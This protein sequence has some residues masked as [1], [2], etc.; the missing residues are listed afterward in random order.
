MA[1][2]RLVWDEHLTNILAFLGS[3]FQGYNWQKML[4]DSLPQRLSDF[5]VAA[6][7]APQR[8]KALEVFG[9]EANSQARR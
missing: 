3:P 6:M 1:A 9:S 4:S 7:T 8:Q 2:I 5:D